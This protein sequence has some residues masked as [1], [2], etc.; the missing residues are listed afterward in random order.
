M[1]TPP[2]PTV[3]R[4]AGPPA[5][6]TLQSSVPPP[7]LVTNVMVEPSGVHCEFTARQ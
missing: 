2:M 3:R 1:P 6:V 5:A 7:R 4:V